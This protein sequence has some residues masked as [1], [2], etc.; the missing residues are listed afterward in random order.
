ME[1]DNTSAYQ[2][3]KELESVYAE[4]ATMKAAS[5]GLVMRCEFMC[6]NLSGAKKVVRREND[7]I[8]AR[9]SG[10]PFTN[11]I[12]DFAQDISSILKIFSAPNAPVEH[13]EL[14]DDSTVMH[15]DS[16]VGH[17]E[18]VVQSGRLVY[19]KTTSLYVQDT[20]TGLAV[21][22]HTETLNIWDLQKAAHI[23]LAS[24]IEKAREESKNV[25]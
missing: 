18:R 5:M 19:R 15:E 1:N 10:H 13:R 7:V 9:W 17:A 2:K 3:L 6:Y 12:S 21:T 22:V 24:Y 25:S 8:V 4:V 23:K 16:A 11:E 14:L 20:L